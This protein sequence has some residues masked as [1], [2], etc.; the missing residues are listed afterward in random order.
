MKPSSEQ[1]ASDACLTANF[2]SDRLLNA[3]DFRFSRT[4]A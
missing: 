2:F 3:V 4:A 1:R